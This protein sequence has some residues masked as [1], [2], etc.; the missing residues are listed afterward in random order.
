[1][2]RPSEASTV[3]RPLVRYA[4]QVSWEYL[5]PEDALALRR[6]ETG[7]VLHDV[8]V[9][10]LLTLNTGVVDPE[11]AERV[12]R[13]LITVRPTIEGNLD[14]WEMLLGLGTIFVEAEKRERNVTLLHPDPAKNVFHVTQEM[15]FSNGVHTI[16]ADVAL[17][18][19]GIP[20]MIAENK[21]A[22]ERG[23]IAKALDQFRRYHREAPELTAVV[24]LQALVQL[25]HFFYG[26][27]WN[28][29]GKSLLNWKDEAAG[30]FED[31]VKAFVTPQHVLRTI[32]DFI[33]FVRAEGELTKV[34]LRPH[35][36]RAVDRVVE[37][38]VHE[39]KR[40]GLVWHTQGSGKTYS[41]IVA[42]KKLIEHP[43]LSNPT[44][45]MLVDRNE[46]EAQLFGNLEALGMPNVAVANSKKHLKELLAEDRR[47]VIVSM[48]HKFDG[49][50][51]D[52]NTRDNFFV[53]VDEA[54]RTTGG[55]LGNYLMG[56]LPNATYIG[57][58]GTPIDR[59]SH[60]KGTFKVFGTD[61][62]EKRY[63]DKYSILESIQ[64]R[65][66]VPLH[67][68]LAPNDLR[69][70]R[71]VLEEEFLDLAEAEGVSDVEDLN[72]VLDRAVRLKNMLK[73]EQRIDRVARFMARHFA[74]NVEPLGY[75]AFVVAV[76]RHACVL[77]KDA[78]DKYLPGVTSAVVISS[79]HNDPPELAAHH[80]TDEQERN[81]R[82]AFRDPDKD[83]KI[84]IVTEKLLT[85]F[86]APVLYAMYLDKP[87]RDH[88]L[89]QAIARVNRPF[90]V[91][92]VRK[93][94]GFV[95][96][97]VG[98]FEKLEKALA[99][100][101]AD[102]E[103]V[104]HDLGVLKDHFV[105]LMDKGL[106]HLAVGAGL[107][108][109][110]RA[111]ALLEHYREGEVRDAFYV[112]FRQL[113]ETYEILSPDPFLRE[114]LEDYSALA[115]NYAVLR[116]AFDRV[117]IDRSFARKTE[118][119]VQDHTRSG[120]ISSPEGIYELG[121]DALTRISDADTPDRV[122]VFNLLKLIEGKLRDEGDRA[123]YLIP[124]GERA[125]KIIEAFQERQ[126]ETQQ[127]LEQLRLQL[128]AIEETERTGR[129][130]GLTAEAMAGLFLLQED[131]VKTPL[132]IAAKM[133]EVLERFPHW[134]RSEEQEREL[135]VELY[136]ALAG[137]GPD[138]D[139][140]VD[141]LLDLLSRGSS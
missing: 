63:L 141:R 57:F 91:D 84:L 118:K 64:D 1:M 88:V 124:I 130:A 132:E 39:S 80:L 7:I 93:P 34:V 120:V 35:Q 86:D 74:E 56:A 68:A 101:S 13:D 109:D 40:R 16:R 51:A 105:E 31:L 134:R 26:A 125:E 131:G 36:M 121:E 78:L 73:N 21:A 5:K 77:Y 33:L 87:M 2:A 85:G 8:L 30:S 135:R 83:P 72:R 115:W 50:P 75:K 129:D 126:I 138:H 136:K 67:Y 54:H 46:L 95:L 28:L 49:I 3:Q 128:D 71:D 6:G 52:A 60:G 70:D 25:V 102:I 38:A 117:E 76:D 82:K 23:G 123:P 37:R 113:E 122:K 112:F 94:A 20:V 69:V 65:A 14:A 110:K 27:T 97:F 48:I 107:P 59:S 58:T 24:Q 79:G 45:L 92:D 139:Q 111:D 11:G 4:T 32:L 18:V 22:T 47:G 15:R 61:D 119:L 9:D 19:N 108:D 100:D 127:A 99:F 103:G 133:A 116:S 98:I 114:H 41:M 43:D 106:E 90:E 62:P 10:Q 140:I 55:D 42:A 81:V 44:V 96:D 137:A 29:D 17:F 89:L 53:L 66:T 12:V 104:V